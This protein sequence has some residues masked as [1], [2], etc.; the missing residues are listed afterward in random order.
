MSWMYINGVIR[1]F[2]EGGQNDNFYLRFRA[3]L[4]EGQND[5]KNI[6]IFIERLGLLI[7]SVL[8]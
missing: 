8:F 7:K 1:C 3:K 4:Q 2:E 6:V 5:F